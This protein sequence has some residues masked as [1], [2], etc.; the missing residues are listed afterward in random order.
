MSLSATKL[1]FLHHFSPSSLPAFLSSFCPSFLLSFPPSVL[2]LCF[3][4]IKCKNHSNCVYRC[5]SGLVLYY[6]LRDYPKNL[7]ASLKQAC[8]TSHRVCEPG[9][10]I[11]RLYSSEGLI[12]GAASKLTHWL[13]AGPRSAGSWLEASVPCLVGALEGC[14]QCD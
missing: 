3:L 11:T 14:P 10:L 2:P 6:C 4:F 8:I 9:I 1:H 5:N 12:G 7:A 13:G